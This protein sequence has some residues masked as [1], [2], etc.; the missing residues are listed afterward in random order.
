MSGID[1]DL[2]IMVED[3]AWNIVPDLE[4]VALPALEAALQEAA[5]AN[6]FKGHSVE[7]SLLFTNDAAMRLLNKNWRGFDKSTNILSFPA[8]LMPHHSEYQ[9][10]G[11]IA[12]AYETIALEALTDKK[13]LLCHVI[14][15]IVHGVLHL[16]GYDHE[17]EH[18]AEMME[19]T[20]IRV[21]AR[22]GIANPY[23]GGEAA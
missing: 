17:T 6:T 10:L 16:V 3:Q 11:D 19:A 21:L 14:H 4:A 2:S 8:P 23:E 9:P 1:I 5:A 12:L 18:E 20:E 13:E 15:L 7:I 22:L